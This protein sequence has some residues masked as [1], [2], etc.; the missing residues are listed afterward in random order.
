MAICVAVSVGERIALVRGLSG[1]SAAEL[2]RRAGLSRGTLP[3]LEAGTNKQP[4]AKTLLALSQATGV[5]MEW[6]LAGTGDAPTPE[7]VKAALGISNAEDPSPDSNA[8][9]NGKAKEPAA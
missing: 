8:Q 6:F 4:G 3:L 2:G 5:P 9:P 7:S 1:L